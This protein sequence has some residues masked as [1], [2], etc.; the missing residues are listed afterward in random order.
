MSLLNAGNTHATWSKEMT[1]L[2]TRFALDP[3]LYTIKDEHQKGFDFIPLEEM[4][5]DNLQGIECYGMLRMDPLSS[6]ETF[7]KPRALLSGKTTL[8]HKTLGQVLPHDTQNT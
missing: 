4:T 6:L 7:E 3:Y 8:I 2:V 5:V 1:D